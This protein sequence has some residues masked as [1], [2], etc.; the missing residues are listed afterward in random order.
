MNEVRICEHCNF[1]NPINNL[2]CEKCGYDL[3][4]IIPISVEDIGID[5]MVKPTEV[6]KKPTFKLVSLDGTYE[7]PISDGLMIGREGTHES[8]FEKSEYVSRQH[9][10]FSIENGIM[11][12]MD[13]SVNGT[14]VNGKKLNKLIKTAVSNLDKI[15]FADISF[16]VRNAN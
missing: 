16:E 8:F 10:I 6:E 2:E 13:A 12:V 1:H 4:F 5:S 15:T 3:S 11:Y 7:I 9:A 14:Y